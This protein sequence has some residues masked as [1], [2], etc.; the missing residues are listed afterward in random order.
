MARKRE[1]IDV[2]NKVLILTN[3]QASESIY[4]KLLKLKQKTSYAIKIKTINKDPLD[5]VTHA[6][7][8]ADEY[9]HVWC[10]F[11]IDDFHQQNRIE[12]AYKKAKEHR[13]ISIAC[14]NQSFEVWL[15]NHFQQFKTQMHRSNYATTLIE[16]LREN[17]ILIDSYDKANER[18]IQ[19][20]FINRY[21]EALL[22]SKVVHQTLEKEFKL[23]HNLNQQA[24]PI[25]F[26][27]PV[28]TVYRLIEF[29][30]I[31]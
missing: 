1:F 5:L 20:H 3:G 11:D 8:I 17:E 21:R 25:W 7:S 19:T 27:E 9:F 23:N 15:I 18:L 6:C 2:N 14:S 29:L 4:F 10:V 24:V 28:T 16:A 31:K 26:L 22:N 13:N 30:F 12:P